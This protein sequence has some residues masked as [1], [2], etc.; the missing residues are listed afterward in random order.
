MGLGLGFRVGVRIRS[1][2]FC[3]AEIA[4][5]MRKVLGEGNLAASVSLLT[6][7]YLTQT[8]IKDKQERREKSKRQKKA[9]GGGVCTVSVH[10]AQLL[11]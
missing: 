8:Q 5:N 3:L 9:K 10:N 11:L 2:R 4:K 6:M 7:L 1:A